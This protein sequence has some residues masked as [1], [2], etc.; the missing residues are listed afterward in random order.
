M[1]RMRGDQAF[2][3][4]KTRPGHTKT[5]VTLDIVFCASLLNFPIVLFALKNHVRCTVRRE[6]MLIWIKM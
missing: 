1:E 6:T 2:I 5:N 3:S 4:I